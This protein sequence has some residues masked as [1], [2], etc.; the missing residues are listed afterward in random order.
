MNKIGLLSMVKN[1]CDIIEQFVRHNQVFFDWIEIIENGSS[2]TTLSILTALQ[3][4]F[5]QLSVGQDTTPGYTQAERMTQ[6]YRELVAHREFDYLLVLDADELLHTTD[7]DYLRNVLRSSDTK[8]FLEWANY[9]PTA[10]D[11]PAIV[12]PF[13]RIRYRNKK[14][15]VRKVVI[16]NVG[17]ELSGSLKIWQGNHNFTLSDKNFKF[18]LLEVP[19]AHFPVRSLEQIQTKAAVGW[20]AYQLKNRRANWS[21]EGFQWR[22]LYEKIL[23]GELRDKD[24][25]AIADN[26]SQLAHRDPLGQ[27]PVLVLDPV[28]VNYADLKHAGI[29][30]SALAAVVFFAERLVDEVWRLKDRETSSTGLLRIPAFRSFLN[31]GLEF[32]R[33]HG[34]LA[35]FRKF[36][37][38]ASRIM[39]VPDGKQADS[40]PLSQQSLDLIER[41][42][43]PLSRLPLKGNRSVLFV[44]EKKQ[45]E[46]QTARYRVFNLS[47]GLKQRGWTCGVLFADDLDIA[48]LPR[49]ERIASLC[50]FVRVPFSPFAS[51]LMNL[52][53]AGGSVVGFDID[54]LVFDDHALI[55]K[56]NKTAVEIPEVFDSEMTLSHRDR[57]KSFRDMMARADFCTASTT[58]LSQRQEALNL[59]SYVIPNSNGPSERSYAATFQRPR[60]EGAIVIG[61]FAGSSTHNDDFLSASEAL[62]RILVEFETVELFVMG[63]LRL[64]EYL[65]TFPAVRIKRQ[66]RG[67]TAEYFAQLGECDINL[68]PLEDIPFNHCKSEL[69]IFEA[70]LFGI[71]SVASRN[72]TTAACILNGKSGFLVD[73]PEDWYR[74]LKVLVT[75]AEKRREMGEQAKTVIARTFDYETVSATADVTYGNLLSQR[76]RRIEVE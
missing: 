14:R 40:V 4:E 6:K 69:K 65:L 7:P 34:F 59:T 57:A 21:K 68:V 13:K 63:P 32:L 41:Y 53:R 38:V 43:T 54:D 12:D 28:A 2:D 52:F 11:D 16:P 27:T 36:L 70:A 45:V 76:D 62:Y 17:K 74:A 26:Y 23:S 20:L 51:D 8:Y 30:R 1:E 29:T 37:E 60:R 9:V 35:T 56:V 49:A 61:Y 47:E 72:P 46:W 24:I 15:Q 25:T 44:I 66:S 10:D 31:R 19:L 42:Q 48:K 3:K 67:T 5:P 18:E 64:P 73:E 58:A 71:P 55:Q 22:F 75:D 39:K 33:N 50:I